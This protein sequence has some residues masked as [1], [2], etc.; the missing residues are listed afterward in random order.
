MRRLAIVIALGTAAAFAHTPS[1]DDVV[2][3]IGSPAAR[4]AAGVV[5]AERDAANPRVLLVRVGAG[6]FALAGQAR[7]AAA[8]EWR[9][10]WR[11]AVP[12]GVVA[13]LDAHTDRPVVRYGRGGTVVDVRS[14]T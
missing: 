5:R 9:A 6:W 7:A 12:G 3:S 1:P 8:A 2:A 13:V 14:G 10:A 4:A 11:H